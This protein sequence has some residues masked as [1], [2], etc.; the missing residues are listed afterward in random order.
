MTA[1]TPGAM[2]APMNGPLTGPLSGPPD[3][4]EIRTDRAA[5][6]RRVKRA[7]QWEL[8]A[9]MILAGV[10][11][12]GF[13]A[14]LGAAG[15]EASVMAPL[16]LMLGIMI[17][18][19][20]I[21]WMFRGPIMWLMRREMPVPLVADA[22]GVWMAVPGTAEGFVR[23]PWWAVRSVTMRGRGDGKAVVVVMRPDVAP[24]APGVEGLTDKITVGAARRGIVVST[25]GTNVT[26]RQTHAV[27]DQHARH[28]AD[29]APGGA[30]R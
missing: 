10:V 22:H 16:G 30:P 7:L 29:T 24:N 11:S 19:A 3:R 14:A 27:L 13:V 6:F 25:Y 8:S 1:P 26:A 15:L 21:G 5:V 20:F 28:H 12:G 17:V 4:F 2:T 23:L 9:A 18:S